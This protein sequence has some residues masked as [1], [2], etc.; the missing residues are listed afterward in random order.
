MSTVAADPEGGPGCTGS[1]IAADPLALLLR[2]FAAGRHN[3]PHVCRQARYERFLHVMCCELLVQAKCTVIFNKAQKN[4]LPLSSGVRYTSGRES[5]MNTPSSCQGQCSHW[6]LLWSR[7]QHTT[8]ESCGKSFCSCRTLCQRNYY[9]A[10]YCPREP[11]DAPVARSL[12]FFCHGAGESARLLSLERVRR[13]FPRSV[14]RSITSPVL[15]VPPL[16]WLDSGVVLEC[17][18]RRGGLSVDAADRCSPW[19]MFSGLGS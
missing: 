2:I 4:R 11:G 10:L 19:G 18:R 14:V 15:T 12:G 7:S 1:D 5:N 9:A 16:P 8:I 3:D 13:S 6:L 17:L